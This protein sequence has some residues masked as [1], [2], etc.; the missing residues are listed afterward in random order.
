MTKIAYFSHTDSQVIDLVVGLAPAGFEVTGKSGEI[1]D[2]E[3]IEIIRDAD[4]LMLLG[5]RQSE[6]VLRS[7]TKVKLLQL[8]SAG[9]DNVDLDLIRKLGIPAANVGGANRQ[10]VAELTIALIL[11]VLRRLNQI[12]AGLKA[13]KWK[14]KLSNGLDTFE[15]AGKTVGIVG[16]GMIGQMVARLLR[17]FDNRILYSDVNTYAEVGSELGAIR[18]PLDELLGEADIVTVHTPLLSD[19]R[20]LIS[21]SELS[22]MKP[23]AILINR[24]RGEVL[25]DAALIKALKEKTIW[26]AGLDVFEQEPINRDNPLLAMEN[27]VLSPHVAGLTYESWPRRAHFAYENFQ[28]VLRGDQPQSIVSP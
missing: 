18:V 25:D 15:L 7:G 8:L 26:A 14:D 4:F 16:F 28:R 2:D 6:R 5:G 24:S 20:K 21:E 17:G 13:D 27:V 11:A 23:T 1:S 3:K 12:E 22:L 9:Y 10:G 19:T